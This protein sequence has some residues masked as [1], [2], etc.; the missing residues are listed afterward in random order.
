MLE[1]LFFI[2]FGVLL[3]V[4]ALIGVRYI[5]K[6]QA[7]HKKSQNIKEQRVIMKV[8]GD[9]RGTSIA[10]EKKYFVNDYLKDSK[11]RSPEEV[12]ADIE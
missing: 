7:G 8:L 6:K 10:I 4:Y 12:W 2:V 1:F 11:I 9:V 5:Q 3:A